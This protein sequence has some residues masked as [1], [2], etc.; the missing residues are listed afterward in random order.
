MPALHL[1][2]DVSTDRLAYAPILFKQA[3][4]RRLIAQPLYGARAGA[5][6]RKICALPLSYAK[7]AGAP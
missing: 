3:C 6:A 1:A 7:K 4:R 5:R 2:A